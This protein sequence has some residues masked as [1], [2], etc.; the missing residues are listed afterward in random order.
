MGIPCSVSSDYQAISQ[1]R[2]PALAVCND[3]VPCFQTSTSVQVATGIFQPLCARKSVDPRALLLRTKARRLQSPTP[4]SRLTDVH[5]PCLPTP[6]AALRLR[7][8][9][10]PCYCTTV[11][12]QSSGTFTKIS[13]LKCFF[14]GQQQQQQQWDS[15]SCSLSSALA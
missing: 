12:P 8:P 2:T 14:G 4:N 7:S 15:T 5:T 3:V 1:P 13:N 6:V 11:P 9:L 10:A